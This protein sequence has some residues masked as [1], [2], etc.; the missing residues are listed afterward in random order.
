MHRLVVLATGLALLGTPAVA[1][2]PLPDEVCSEPGGQTDT[3]PQPR[4]E[5]AV[6]AGVPVAVVLPVGYER[7]RHRYPVVY[8][9]HGAQGDEDSWV[10]YGGLMASTA[11]QRDPAIVVMPKM[12]V[13]TGFATDW[14]DGFRKDATFLSTTLVRWA[15]ARYRTRPDRDARAIAGYSGGALSAIHVAERSPQVFGSVGVLS[16]PTDLS[17][18]ATQ[19]FTQATFVAEQLCAG[20][21]ATAAGVLGDPVTN[22]EAWT[23]ADPTLHVDRLRD[24]TVYV[25]SGNGQPCDAADATN[26]LYPTASTEGQMRQAHEKLAAA[27][28][29]AGVRHTSVLRPCGLHWWT[30]W[31]PSL[32]EFWKVAAARWRQS[33]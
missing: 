12:G 9:L 16:G 11:A 32:A 4:F 6:V 18:P 27:L 13:V 5:R 3:A 20:D 22:P 19:P 33:R 30:T 29:A 10:E 21:D 28:V 17:N 24:T 7:G 23:A 15:D 2:P 31:T 1:A 26:L 14:A 25:T 8:L